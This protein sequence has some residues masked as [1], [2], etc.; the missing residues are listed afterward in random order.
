MKRQPLRVGFDLDGV[1]LYNPARIARPVIVFL[2][3]L[4]IPKEQNKFH[5]PKNKLQKLLWFILHK[6]SFTISAG[7][8]DLKQ[9]VNEGRIETFIVSG[10]Y[11]SLK[12][13]FNAWLNKLEAKKYFKSCHYNRVD[14]QPN[15]F[16]EKIIKKLNLDI[17][18]EDN[19]DIVRHLSK[20]TD[21]KIFWIYNLLD[22]NIKYKY[23]F[24]SL[25]KAVAELNKLST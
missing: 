5:L 14:E 20:K 9:L 12:T 16:K 25:K 1:L 19:W 8:N 24:P 10:R 2:K 13:D 18:I 4:F 17:F 3:K 23:K 22:R 7:Y 21:A 15:L 11:D 6:S